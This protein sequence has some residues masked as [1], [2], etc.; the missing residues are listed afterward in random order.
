M[1]LM[2]LQR[3]PLPSHNKSSDYNTFKQSFISSDNTSDQE[4]YVNAQDYE[5]DPLEDGYESDKSGTT[6]H[7]EVQPDE[8]VLM[9]QDHSTDQ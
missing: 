9:N 8:D 7:N 1:M 3:F 6:I 4:Q 2:T 5:A